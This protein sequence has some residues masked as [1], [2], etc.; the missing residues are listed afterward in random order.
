MLLT[1]G[2]DGG[3]KE[4]LAPQGFPELVGGGVAQHGC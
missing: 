1:V 4:W 3:V 2:R